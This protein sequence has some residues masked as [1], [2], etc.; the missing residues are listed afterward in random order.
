MGRWP[1]THF[2]TFCLIFAPLLFLY[3]FLDYRQRKWH[4]MLVDFCYYQ[5]SLT[6][7]FVTS[8]PKNEMLFRACFLSANGLLG[9]ATAVFCN[10][11]II[12]KVDYIV[13]IVVHLMPM[14]IM[15]NLT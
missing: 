6:L 8:D 12:H 7:Y 11:V 1:H 3:R 15:Y 2:Y 13:S 4:L 10:K 9:V 5:C 14:M